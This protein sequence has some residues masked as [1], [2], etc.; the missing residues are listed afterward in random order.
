MPRASC[1]PLTAND[2]VWYMREHASG[3]GHEWITPHAHLYAWESDLLTVTPGGQVCEVEVK[4]SR[5]DLR[6]DLLKPK[7]SRGM[8]LNG[9][10]FAKETGVALTAA[11]AHENRRRAAGAERCR[12]PNFFCFAMPCR[13]YRAGP[14]LRLP[15]YAGLYTVDDQGRVFEERRPVQ[16]HGERIA[17]EDLLALARR[18]HRRYWETVRRG[19]EAG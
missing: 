18:M 4:I 11:E 12:R 17:A 16:L 8:L 6:N 9:S 14:P 2:I 10:F 7:H 1:S 5:G 19:R 3:L 15:P 13:V